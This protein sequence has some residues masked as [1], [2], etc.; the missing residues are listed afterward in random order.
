MSYMYAYTRLPRHWLLHL[1][2]SN[3]HVTRVTFIIPIYLIACVYIVAER[4]MNRSLL[5]NVRER[6][7]RLN[8]K[9]FVIYTK[10]V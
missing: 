2:A 1:H 4:F 5:R 8:C 7:H 3:C 6:Y 9:A 10:H